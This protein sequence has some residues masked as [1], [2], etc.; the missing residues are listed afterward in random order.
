MNVYYTDQ[1]FVIHLV[2]P[3]VMTYQVSTKYEVCYVAFKSYIEREIIYLA[4]LRHSACLEPVVV[5]CDIS[6]NV[7][8]HMAS[9]SA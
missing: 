7:L 2:L 4:I 3:T 9:C 5:I 1:S 8:V 6:N